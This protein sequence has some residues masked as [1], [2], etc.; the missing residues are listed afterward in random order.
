MSLQ[1]EGTINSMTTATISQGKASKIPTTKQQRTDSPYGK[2]YRTALWVYAGLF[3]TFLYGPLL[4]I[5]VLSFNSS[6]RKSVL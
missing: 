1:V 2:G 4:M 3:Y 5:I 6:D